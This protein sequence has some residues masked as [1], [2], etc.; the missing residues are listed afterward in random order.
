MSEMTHLIS[1]L[2]WE[3]KD[4]IGVEGKNQTKTKTPQKTTPKVP[5]LENRSGLLDRVKKF[6]SLAIQRQIDSALRFISI[7]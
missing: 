4:Y 6:T 2:G 5:T 3:G 7:F 1:S